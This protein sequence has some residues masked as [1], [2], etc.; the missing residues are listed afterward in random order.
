MK[1]IIRSIIMFLVFCAIC[2]GAWAGGSSENQNKSQ[3]A[4][5]YS[6]VIPAADCPGIVVVAI[7]NA[8]GQYRI[9]YQYIDRGTEVFVYSGT[10]KY[11]EKAKTITLDSGDL[12]RFYKSGKNSLTQLDLEGN[13]IKGQFADNYVLR[14][15]KTAN[16]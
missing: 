9:T 6:G 2:S 14:K 3:W 10:F 12:P 1:N 11:D 5:I 13:I 8:N 4:G 16:I 15:V 7:L